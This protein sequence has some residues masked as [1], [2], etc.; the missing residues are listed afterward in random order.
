MN[1][2]DMNDVNGERLDHAAFELE[3]R[4]I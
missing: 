4:V 3:G 2:N 1:M